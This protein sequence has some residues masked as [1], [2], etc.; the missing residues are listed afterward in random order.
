MGMGG[1]YREFAPPELL[2]NT[3]TFDES[4]Y[5]GEAPDT[6]VL[7]EQAGATTATLTVLYESRAARDGVLSSPMADGLGESYDKLA[8]L[9]TEMS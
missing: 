1:V 8:A 5:P 4:W 2:V 3:E 7:V 9:L 6:L